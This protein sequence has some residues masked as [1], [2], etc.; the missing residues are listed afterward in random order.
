MQL[1]FDWLRCK[2]FNSSFITRLLAISGMRSHIYSSSSTKIHP[3]LPPYSTPQPSSVALLIPCYKSGKIIGATLKAALKRFP[4]ENI[5][6]IAN[7]NS[8]TPLDNIGDVCAEYGISHTWPP[9]GSKIIAQFVVAKRFNHILLIYDDCLLPPTFPLGT[10]RFSKRIKCI[11]YN[12]TSVSL[13][14]NK[15]TLVQQAQDLEYK[16]PACGANSPVS[17]DQLPSPMVQSARGT[18]NSFSKPST[19]IQASL[20]PNIGSLAT[21]PALLPA[22]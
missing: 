18:E 17:L 15:G 8:P 10:D 9:L 21:S 11:G 16:L 1:R 2:P 7:G 5:F 13:E 20:S 6:M 12:I 3:P 19:A 4:Q 22:G 14:G